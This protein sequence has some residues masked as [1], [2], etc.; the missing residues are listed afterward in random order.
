MHTDRQMMRLNASPFMGSKTV[1][2]RIAGQIQCQPY[3]VAS[4]YDA[5]I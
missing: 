3:V 5:R 1:I 4:E 2:N